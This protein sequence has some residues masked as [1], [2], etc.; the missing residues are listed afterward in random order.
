MT[1]PVPG[2]PHRP[3]YP[4]HPGYGQPG[5]IPGPPPPPPYSPSPYPGHRYPYMQ[6]RKTRF[7]I[8]LLKFNE[9]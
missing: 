2:H 7:F 9:M 6:P 3:L 5:F 1:Y 4:H 8:K